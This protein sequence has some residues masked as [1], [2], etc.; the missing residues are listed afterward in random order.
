MRRLVKFLDLNTNYSL[1]YKTWVKHGAC[2]ILASPLFLNNGVVQTKISPE[3][4][5]IKRLA[6][7]GQ[8]NNF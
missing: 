2:I 3:M 5:Y 1:T 8:S 4:K 7:A 6:S